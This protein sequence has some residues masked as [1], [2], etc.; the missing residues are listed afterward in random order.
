MRPVLALIVLILAGCSAASIAAPIEPAVLT[1]F[2]AASLKDAFTELGQQFEMEHPGVAVVFNLAGSQ[3]LAQQ[4]SAGAPAD[5]FASAS[6]PPMDVVAQAGRVIDG[7]PRILAR[8]KLA[9]IYPVDNP[10]GLVALKDLAQP[11]LRLVLAAR[12]APAGQYALAFLDK[13]SGHPAFG[14]AFK[15]AVLA[16]V[17]SYEETVRVVFGKVALGEAD[18]GIVYVSDISGDNAGKVG[19]IDIP[20][21]LNPIAIY[22]IAPIGDS[23]HPELAAAFIDLALSPRGQAVLARYGF[24]KASE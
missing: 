15:A 12:E 19:R 9:V 7:T 10:A 1:L 24:I 2:A 6:Q 13:A 14:S 8:N 3:Q 22:L 5:V 18:A 11:G 16:N 21:A 20:D 17:V 4:L 23:P